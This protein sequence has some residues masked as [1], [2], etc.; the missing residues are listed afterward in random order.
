MFQIRHIHT[1][2]QYKIYQIKQNLLGIG[3]FKIA[4]F[5][6]SKKIKFQNLPNEKSILVTPNT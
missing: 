2:I 1:L 4:F 5:V 6:Q 3:T